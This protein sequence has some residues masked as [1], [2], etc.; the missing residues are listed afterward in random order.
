MSPPCQPYTFRGGRHDVA[1]S[2]AQ[3]LLRLIDLIASCG[4]EFLLL[5]NVY[6]FSKSIAFQNLS[7]QLDRCG[8]R[9]QT[10][11]LCPTAMNWPNKRPRFYLIAS[12]GSDVASWQELPTYSIRT[13]DLVDWH[14]ARN[15]ARSDR[16]TPYERVRP[17]GFRKM[18]VIAKFYDRR[19]AHRCR[20]N[21]KL[22][23][24]PSRTLFFAPRSE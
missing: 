1:D 24:V 13:H 18:K 15:E 2:R 9:W 3:S 10:I 19:F 21:C 16:K 17:S 4:P 22:R 6:G 12:L 11:E 8:Y 5:E 14:I 7:Q 20:S 23:L